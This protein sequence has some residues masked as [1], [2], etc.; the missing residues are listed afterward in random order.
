MADAARRARRRPRAGSSSPS[1]ARRSHAFRAAPQHRYLVRSVDP[2]D[3]AALPPAPRPSS[4][5][6]RSAEADER[7]LLTRARIEAIVAKNSG[8]EATYGK[9]AAARALGLEVVL[10]DRPPRREAAASVEAL[11]ARLD[12]LADPA[13]SA[14]CRPA[15]QR[16]PRADQP[17]L[18]P[19]R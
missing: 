12:H 8:G 11:I 13:P 9:I 6:A 19:S 17:R 7:A 4:P 3:P 14:A 5:A 15:A 18:A 1:A 10:V 16:R 2:L